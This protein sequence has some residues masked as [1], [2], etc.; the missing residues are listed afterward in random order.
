[1][2]DEERKMLRR[3]GWWGSRGR[4][5]F[6]CM[7]CRVFKYL[8]AIGISKFLSKDELFRS[9]IC[10]IDLYQIRCIGTSACRLVV[11][12]QMNSPVQL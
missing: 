11:S 4:K 9:S 3:A 5:G 7:A 2:A 10:F 1:M 6:C 12:V 8:R